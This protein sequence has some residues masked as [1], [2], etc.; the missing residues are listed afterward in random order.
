MHTTKTKIK[1]LGDIHGDFSVI[2]RACARGDLD[3]HL[4]IQVGDFGL[5][6]GN[7]NTERL[8]ME[9]LNG[10]LEESDCD[11]WVIRGNHCNPH[12]YTGE[13]K[14]EFEKAYSRIKLIE[15][16]TEAEIN[17]ESVLLFGGA[18][19]VDKCFRTEWRTW[20]EG[21]HVST[22]PKDLKNY[23][24]IISHTTPSA[25][26]GVAKDYDL[27]FW[28]DRDPTLEYKLD[29]ERA[30]VE[31]IYKAVNPKRWYFGHFHESTS[32]VH[33]DCLWQCIDIN[34]IIEL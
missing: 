18:V 32:E 21:E 4:L 6:F 29:N 26:F 25:M 2:K 16:Y 24:V 31:E 8:A 15:D 12:Y 22:P 10:G 7:A 27:Q 33:E 14:S 28:Y 11:L 20:W 17:G 23:D 5:G 34:E 19:S 30:R 9:S 1:L 13:K 3:D